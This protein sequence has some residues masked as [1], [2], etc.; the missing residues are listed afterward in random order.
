MEYN[1]CMHKCH[2]MLLS[3]LWLQSTKDIDVISLCPKITVA[4]TGY[5]PAVVSYIPDPLKHQTL[6]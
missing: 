3:S 4:H 5:H 1:V 2:I 6:H